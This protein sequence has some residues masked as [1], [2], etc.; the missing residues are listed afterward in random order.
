VALCGGAGRSAVITQIQGDEQ[1]KFAA[2]ASF[3]ALTVAGTPEG[4]QRQ[5]RPA[6]YRAGEGEPSFRETAL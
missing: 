4:A 3:A 6:L 2:L 1:K 5:Q